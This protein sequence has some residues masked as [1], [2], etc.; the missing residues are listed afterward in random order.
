MH[1]LRLRLARVKTCM[2][3][4]PQEVL[5]TAAS[6]LLKEGCPSMAP[7]RHRLETLLDSPHLPSSPHQVQFQ[8]SG[9]E[10]L[11]PDRNLTLPILPCHLSLVKVSATEGQAPARWVSFSLLGWSLGSPLLSGVREDE[12]QPDASTLGTEA[13]WEEGFRR[14]GI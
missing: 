5:S 3:V 11:I 4:K 9:P 2:K 10:P 8:T 1:D 6:C 14:A 12:I 13:C 7:K